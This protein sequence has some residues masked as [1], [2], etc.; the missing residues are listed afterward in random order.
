MIS[1]KMVSEQS[2]LHCR[3]GFSAEKVK[4]RVVHLDCQCR[5][6]VLRR[7]GMMPTQLPRQRSQEVGCPMELSLG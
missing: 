1:T 7:G 3:C 5:G 4:G 6:G 2:A